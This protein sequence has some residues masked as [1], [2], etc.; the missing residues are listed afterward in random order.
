MSA[1]NISA[2]NRLAETLSLLKYYPR[3]IPNSLRYPHSFQRQLNDS[4]LSEDSDDFQQ[5]KEILWVLETAAVCIATTDSTGS[6]A[7]AIEGSIRDNGPITL[8]LAKNRNINNHDQ[9]IADEF[10]RMFKSFDFQQAL[11]FLVIHGRDNLNERIR[12]L[13]QSFFKELLSYTASHSF[14]ESAGEEFRNRFTTTVL[15]DRKWGNKPVR[16]ILEY[17]LGF[18][19]SVQEL[20]NNIEAS[21]TRFVNLVFYT[22]MLRSSRYMAFIMQLSED[23]DVDWYPHLREFQNALEQIA[24]FHKLEKLQRFVHDHRHVIK[25][26]WANNIS[27]PPVEDAVTCRPPSSLARQLFMD[28]IK[29]NPRFGMSP[30]PLD[31]QEKRF[32]NVEELVKWNAPSGFWDSPA[33]IQLSLHPEIRIALD[34]AMATAPHHLI[35]C[36]TSACM[37]CILWLDAYSRLEPSVPRWWLYR[38]GQGQEVDVG[39][40]FP[41]KITGVSAILPLDQIVLEDVQKELSFR[42]SEYV[43]VYKWR[44]P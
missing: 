39:W 42:M 40:A 31:V 18:V 3:H 24:S 36:S 43:D 21:H 1:T 27:Y 22:F 11:K 38:L 2:S 35:G 7:A 26:R 44:Y 16:E 15:N 14:K 33:Q 20:D 19:R 34:P 10:L 28:F 12:T 17:L 25:V 8:V 41:G 4:I 6:I 5:D 13:R 29:P 32:K 30:L 37:C 23:P 9:E